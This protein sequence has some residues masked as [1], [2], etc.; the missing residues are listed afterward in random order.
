M[1]REMDEKLV[2][3]AD[4]GDV[5]EMER[6][7]AAGANPNAFEGTSSDTP[8][9]Q[10]AWKGHVAAIAA[11]LK[12]GAHVDG[13]TSEGYTPLMRA[14][15]KGHTAAIDALIAAGADVNRANKNGD[16]AL[17][18]ASS[19]GRLDA[20]R[21]LLEA[22][23]KA[24]VLNKKGEQPI[25][26]VR[27]RRDHNRSFDVVCERYRSRHAIC[28]RRVVCRFALVW[29]WTRPTKPPSARC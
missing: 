17:H 4:R 13:A 18:R 10:A 1:S 2:D 9:Q 7:I 21:V 25:D 24:D 27:D 6:L 23:A 20:V 11:L 15:W 12:A 5:G 19:N 26:M 22:G 14:A 3:A 16:T 28:C 8:L 29:V